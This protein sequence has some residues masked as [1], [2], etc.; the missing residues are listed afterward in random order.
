MNDAAR[1]PNDREGTRGR[2]ALGCAVITAGLFVKVL[3]KISLAS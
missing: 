1:E 3:R 2:F